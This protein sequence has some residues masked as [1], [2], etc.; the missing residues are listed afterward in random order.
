V[1]IDRD[2]AEGKLKVIV[3]LDKGDD[4]GRV[5]RLC[6]HFQEQQVL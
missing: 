5:V 1:E 2:A 4:S 6:G 3:F